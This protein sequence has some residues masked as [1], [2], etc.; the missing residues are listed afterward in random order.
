MYEENILDIDYRKQFHIAVALYTIFLIAL[1]IG[2]IIIGIKFIQNKKL[3]VAETK[4]KD[5]YEKEVNRKKSYL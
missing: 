2:I 4:A 5:E 1:I 3:L